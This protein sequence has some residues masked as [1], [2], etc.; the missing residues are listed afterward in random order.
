SPRSERG[1]GPGR[2]RPLARSR[3]GQAEA[4]GEEDAA[5]ASGTEGDCTE[6]DTHR[7]GDGDGDRTAASSSAPDDVPCNLATSAAGDGA[8]RDDSARE[9]DDDAQ[10]EGEA[11]RHETQAQAQ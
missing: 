3:S 6:A 1:V 4:G 2:E 10:A 8:A 7:A 5:A 9:G 11:S